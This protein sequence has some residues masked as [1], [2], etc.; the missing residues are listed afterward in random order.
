MTENAGSLLPRNVDALAEALRLLI[1]NPSLRN[2]LGS[3]GEQFI[4]HGFSRAASAN[5]MA[6]IYEELLS[7]R[8][9]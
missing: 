2:A 8:R 9:R 1:E 3:R 4:R 7:R 6:E 5:R